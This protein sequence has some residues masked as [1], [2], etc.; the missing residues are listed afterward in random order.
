MTVSPSTKRRSAGALLV[1][2]IAW[3]VWLF[4]TS[5]L[6]AALRRAAAVVGREARY[7]VGRPG[8]VQAGRE[9]RWLPRQV[10][11]PV[12]AYRVGTALLPL[13]GGWHVRHINVE[14]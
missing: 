11:D 9:R 13:E 10:P 5:P 4:V 8:A 12:L 7:W 1:L 14:A 3:L 6:R 2:T